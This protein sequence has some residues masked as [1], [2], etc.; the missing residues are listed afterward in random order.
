MVTDS[1]TQSRILIKHHTSHQHPLQPLRIDQHLPQGPILPQQRLQQTEKA[2]SRGTDF[3]E[4]LTSFLKLGRRLPLILLL[5]LIL[6]TPITHHEE[7][8]A[9][10]F[11]LS[12][13]HLFQ[14][15]LL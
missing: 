12:G 6:S 3:Q 8:G 11:L 10:F 9:A 4:I 1:S 14:N 7:C 5:R 13:D 15:L 2:R